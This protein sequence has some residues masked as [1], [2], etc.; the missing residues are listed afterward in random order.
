MLQS[1]RAHLSSKFENINELRHHNHHH[2]HHRQHR[3][4]RALGIACHAQ[5][6]ASPC[7]ENKC[8][9]Y[10]SGLRPR[11]QHFVPRHHVA[12]SARGL[13]PESRF[14]SRRWATAVAASLVIRP[15]MR[16]KEQASISQLSCMSC[17]R[18]SLLISAAVHHHRNHQNFHQHNHSPSQLE[19]SSSIG[20]GKQF[21]HKRLQC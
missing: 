2:P 12:R 1:L 19:V 21:M 6:L 17:T 13:Y 14:S 18:A 9:R 15:Y 10:P 7:S 8:D 4:T 20:R 5:E 11:R 16:H 3:Q